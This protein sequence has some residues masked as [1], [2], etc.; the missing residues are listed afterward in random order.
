MCLVWRVRPACE[1][2][3]DARPILRLR[4]EPLHC[5]AQLASLESLTERRAT[6]Y[7]F[8]HVAPLAE[9]RRRGLLPLLGSQ[10]SK[11]AEAASNKKEQMSSH[12]RSLV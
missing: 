12:L 4:S 3:H 9:A 7:G 8:D 11:A 6:S 10:Q 5:L 1:E 2:V